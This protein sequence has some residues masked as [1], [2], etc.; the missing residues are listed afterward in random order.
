MS[1]LMLATGLAA[2]GAATTD[3]RM[4]DAAKGVLVALRRCT[5]SE[6]FTELVDAAERYQ[7]GVLAM[8]RA[9]VQLAENSATPVAG[10]AAGAAR[11]AWAHLLG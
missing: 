1:M 10:P 6:A 2:D 7:V 11:T 5:L 3:M 9:L 8:S 4:L